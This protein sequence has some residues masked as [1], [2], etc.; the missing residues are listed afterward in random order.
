MVL[1]RGERDNISVILI[2]TV[3]EEDCG[4]MPELCEC[5]KGYVLEGETVLAHT[6][7]IM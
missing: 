2:R 6:E 4:E 1:D 5:G 7:G 3:G